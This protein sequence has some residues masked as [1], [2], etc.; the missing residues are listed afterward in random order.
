V[1]LT[2]ASEGVEYRMAIGMF[3]SSLRE[4]LVV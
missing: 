3:M 1:D 4:V 2:R